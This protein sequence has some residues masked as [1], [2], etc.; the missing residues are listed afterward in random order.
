M[1]MTATEA[2]MQQAHS[3]PDRTALVFEE[4]VWTYR[5]LAVQS[6]CIARA[7]AASGLKAGDRVVRHM[8]NRAEMLV[9]YDACLWFGAIGRHFA[10]RSSFHSSHHDGAPPARAIYRQSGLLSERCGGR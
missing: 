5:R 4:E 6:D 3:R 10:P 1:T 7:L 2:L 8:M 9:A